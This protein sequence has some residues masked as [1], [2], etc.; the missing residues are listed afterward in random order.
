MNAQEKYIK[1]LKSYLLPLSSEERDD[2]IEFYDEYISD[3]GLRTKQEIEE[4]LGTPRQL[5]HQ[6]LAERSIKANND[7]KSKGQLASTHSSWKVFWLVLIAIVT[8]PLTFFLSLGALIILI[9]ALAVVFGVT[10]GII[11]T[12]FG[13]FVATGIT[14]YTGLSLLATATMVGIFY[15][16]IGITMLGAFLLIIPVSYWI[17]RWLAQ[18]VANLSKYIYQKLVQRRTHKDEKN[19]QD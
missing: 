17:L 2:A 11:G 10:V 9:C 16:G 4:K 13:L 5:G 12:L 7:E 1:E 14:I 15:L 6:I 3:A 8:S 18:V 19:V